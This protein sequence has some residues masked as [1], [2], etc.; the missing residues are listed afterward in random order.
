[1]EEGGI[2]KGEESDSNGSMKEWIRSI[3]PSDVLKWTG[4]AFIVS[5]EVIVVLALVL[6]MLGVFGD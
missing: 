5:L 1:M 3:D 6:S 4:V 2:A